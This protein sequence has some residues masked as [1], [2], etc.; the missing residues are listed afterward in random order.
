M[1]KQKICT[2]GSKH[3]WT[4]LKNINQHSFTVTAKGSSGR[5]TLKGVYRCAC[6]EVRIGQ[7]NHNGPDLREL[8][9]AST[10]EQA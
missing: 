6:D 2:I 9:D 4:W 1:S 3:K 8:V 5:F 10:G 7:P